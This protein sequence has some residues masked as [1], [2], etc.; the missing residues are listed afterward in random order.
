MRVARGTYTDIHAV[1]G[2]TQVVYLTGS[3]M[4]Q[5]SYGT[6]GVMRAENVRITLLEG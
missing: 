1:V 6:D 5:G 4:L 2:V 3:L